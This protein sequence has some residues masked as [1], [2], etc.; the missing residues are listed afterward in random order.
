M[1][2]GRQ[3]GEVIHLHEGVSWG[4]AL[5]RAEELLTMV[6][7]PDAKRRVREFPHSL[8]GGMRQRVV[9]A[10]ALACNP[11][12]LIADEPTTALDVTIQAQVLDLIRDLKN[13]Y[14]AAI[15]LITHDL[16]VVAE[17]AER[18]IIM[19]AGQKVEEAP[20]ESIFRNSRHPYTRA[21]LAAVPILGSSLAGGARSRLAEIPGT[22][23]RSVPAVGCPFAERCSMTLDICRTKTPVL[24]NYE[25]RHLVACHRSHE[26]MIP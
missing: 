13:R 7:I 23:P 19:Y 4:E 8:S 22:V 25:P 6:G 12:L 3:I 9:I 2:I 1:T 24:E 26:E 20:V 5:R 15:V 16:G 21:L 11:K 14:S 10:M 18:V 17:M